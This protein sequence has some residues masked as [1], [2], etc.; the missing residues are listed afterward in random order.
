M[1][2]DEVKLDELLLDLGHDDFNAGTALLREAVKA[3]C[4]GMQLTKELYPTIARK[5]GSTAARVERNIRHSL[6]KAWGRGSVK[7]QFDVFRWSYSPEHGRPTV[8]E[9]IARLARVCSHED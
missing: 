7:A 4:P 9:Y 3:Y 5:H 6:D 8:G 1:K 2:I